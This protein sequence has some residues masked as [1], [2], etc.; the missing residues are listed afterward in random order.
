ML[1]HLQSKTEWEGF[2]ELEMVNGSI[3]A[4][5]GSAILYVCIMENVFPL[6]KINV[7]K[8]N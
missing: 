8:M 6:E 5:H 4:E 3:R 7:L 1:S 2:Q